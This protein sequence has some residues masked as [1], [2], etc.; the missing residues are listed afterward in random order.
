[1][2]ET[3]RDSK[4]SLASATG[5]GKEDSGLDVEG[6][7]PSL[8]DGAVANGVGENAP[9]SPLAAS[10]AEPDNAPA[11]SQ[12][13]PTREEAPRTTGEESSSQSTPLS[14]VNSNI[15]ALRS[16]TATASPKP[17]KRR[18]KFYYLQITISLPKRGALPG[19]EGDRRVE[20]AVGDDAADIAESADKTRE[21]LTTLKAFWDDVSP[22]ELS[23]A[24]FVWCVF[25]EEFTEAA[26]KDPEQ[27]V[28]GHM[29]T[30]LAGNTMALSAFLADVRDWDAFRLLIRRRAGRLPVTLAA[31]G[32]EKRRRAKGKG[33]SPDSSNTSSSKLSMRDEAVRMLASEAFFYVMAEREAE[34][35]AKRLALE[36]ALAAAE[37]KVQ[38][39][40][41]SV[42]GA[43]G[44]AIG[45]VPLHRASQ[46]TDTIVR[47]SLELLKHMEQHSNNSS[48]GGAGGASMPAPSHPSRSRKKQ[49]QQQNRRSGNHHGRGNQHS[50]GHS[51]SLTKKVSFDES[52]IRREDVK[53][54]LRLALEE[55]CGRLDNTESR[56]ATTKEI[57]RALNAALDGNSEEEEEEEEEEGESD[58][59]LDDDEGEY[60]YT[61]PRP[62][63]NYN[64]YS[65]SND[66]DDHDKGG[67]SSSSTGRSR[68]A[69]SSVHRPTYRHT[70]QQTS[71]TDPTG[72]YR[73][74]N[75]AFITPE[76]APSD[77]SDT[78]LNSPE[79]SDL[80]PANMRHPPTLRI[81]GSAFRDQRHQPRRPPQH[82]TP[83]AE[84]E[85][86]HHPSS[87]SYPP[88]R[89]ST[90]PN[91][92]DFRHTFKGRR[93]NESARPTR[94]GSSDTWDDSSSPFRP[95]PP[96]EGGSLG[97]KFGKLLRLKSSKDSLR[98]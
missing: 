39:I 56:E 93:S 46:R 74:D 54:R 90:E 8:R 11:H 91:C 72:L 28:T 58:E 27:D 81:H 86:L 79:D 73:M 82:L 60:E 7:L 5:P 24:E 18:K 45:E 3:E 76:Y 67:S 80:G 83:L 30:R 4:I 6:Y 32:Q 13:Q 68:P 25:G 89:D 70:Q 97:K 59:P 69:L 71:P 66:D 98:N 21:A 41:H 12:Q 52:T 23:F 78:E 53:D 44:G 31:R 15:A 55:A 16:A 96:R 33:D 65:S 29:A 10:A 48:S 36:A 64:R 87:P 1:M 40:V 49:P 42:T 50:T 19:Y 63:R 92:L 62:E 88:P 9:R 95:D 85:D 35:E 37:R 84:D 20:W 51:G 26:A 2:A 94:G 77:N 22:E 61:D 47:G 17:A 34:W 57:W 43:L 38:R 75:A 14:A